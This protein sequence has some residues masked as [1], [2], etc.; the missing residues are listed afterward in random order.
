M[1][2]YPLHFSTLSEATSSIAAT[3]STRV[4]DG[5]EATCAIPPEFEGPGGGYS[6]EDFYALAITN[7]FV[8]TFKVFA[9]K[10]KITFDA[11]RIE[12]LLTVDRNEA[13]HPW[14]KKMDL[15]VKLSAKGGDQERIGRLLTKA[16]Q[17]CLVANSIRTEVLF[18]FD[19]SV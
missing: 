1:I 8:A 14:L 3:W 16:S 11:L 5:R 19:L 7:C 4:G 18:Q 13:G 2:Q 15:Q 17:S 12:G 10:S 9:E 6:P